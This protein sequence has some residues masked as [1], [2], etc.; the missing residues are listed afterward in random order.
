[1]STKVQS[2]RFKI[3]GSNKK[4][5]QLATHNP[6]L[7]F[8]LGG[9]RSGKSAYALKLAE[10]IPGEKVYLATAQALDEEMRE[11]I[12][13]HKKE[14]GN[15]WTTIEE[16]INVVDVIKKNETPPL[17]PSF[18]KWGQGGISGK[19][20]VILLDC[21][22]LWISNLMHRKTGVRRSIDKFVSTCKRSKANIIIVSNEVGLGIVPENH[23]AREFRDIVGYTNQRIAEVS[24]E[25][26]FMTAGIPMRVR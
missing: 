14:R 3:Q 23:L 1:L 22:T 7:I 20:N 21:L 8:I 13:R 25:V 18:S 12:K 6:R 9:A 2:S 11:R 26:Y 19:Y 24:D 15:N 4:D 17:N 16:P 10:S 5:S